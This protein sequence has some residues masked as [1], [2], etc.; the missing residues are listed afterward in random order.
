MS[1]P[2]TK[3]ILLVDDEPLLLRF[4]RT[5]LMRAGYSVLAAASPKEAVRIN[6]DS[7]A[8]IDLL[9]TGLSLRPISGSELASMLRWR[10]PGL[11][12]V[13]MSSD[14]G[15]PR[16]AQ[17]NGWSFT[18]K[19]FAISDLLKTIG[20]ALALDVAM[21]VGDVIADA[22]GAAAVRA[23]RPGNLGSNY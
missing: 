8:P 14:P 2:I 3:T 13:L 23:R 12:V 10:R 22:G 20:D 18:A 11:R 4:I 1:L 7:Q 16:L 21:R 17:A 9:L 5:I 19:P 15:A 6:Q